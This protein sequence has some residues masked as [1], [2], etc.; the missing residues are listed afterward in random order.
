MDPYTIAPIPSYSGVGAEQHAYSDNTLIQ[1][2]RAITL[3]YTSKRL[4]RLNHIVCKSGQRDLHNA[5]YEDEV[6]KNL[7]NSYQK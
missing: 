1:S 6:V 2:I 7:C 4:V 3:M 5:N